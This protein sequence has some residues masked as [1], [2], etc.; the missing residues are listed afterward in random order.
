MVLKI[1]RAPEYHEP[2]AAVAQNGRAVRRH[3]E[4]LTYRSVGERRH[5]ASCLDMDGGLWLAHAKPF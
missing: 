3:S 2:C 4:P 1:A 5:Q